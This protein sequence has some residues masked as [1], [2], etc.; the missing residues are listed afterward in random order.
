MSLLIDSQILGRATVF[1]F[2]F[3]RHFKSTSNPLTSLQESNAKWEKPLEW[4]KYDCDESKIL[5]G[6]K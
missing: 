3:L 2:A 1:F 4:I 5:S 6:V